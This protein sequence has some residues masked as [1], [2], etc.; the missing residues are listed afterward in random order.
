MQNATPKRVLLTAEERREQLLDVTTE[1]VLERGFHEVSIDAVAKNAGITRAVVYQ[2]FDDL[3]DLLHA[4]VDRETARALEQVS[5]T[6]LPDLSTGDARQ[7]MLESVSAYIEAVQS[8]PRTWKLVLMP[9]EGAPGQL[10]KSISAGRALVL[11]QLTSA[12]RPILAET[13][14]AE[15]TASVLSSIADHYARLALTRPEQ[16]PPDRLLAHAD[17]LVEGFLRDAI[18]KS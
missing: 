9:P 11:D 2:H 14:D 4:V 3:S 18:G 16:F 15:L 7:L 6:A 13:T 1:L 8:N 10:R 17:W 12:V 5:R